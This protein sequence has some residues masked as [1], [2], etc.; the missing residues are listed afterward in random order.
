MVSPP[1]FRGSARR[2]TRF[3]V[4]AT[5]TASAAVTRLGLP[6]LANAQSEEAPVGP[7]AVD[8]PEGDQY[9]D[10]DPSALTDF[11]GALD[12]Y[13]AWVDDPSYGTTWTPDPAQVPPTF[14][15]YATDGRW[16]YSGSDYTWVSDYAWGWV[17]FH[18]GRWV[19]AGGRWLWIP[20]R[21]YA[22]AWVDW[23]VG[24]AST[25][26]L[27][28]SPAPPSWI[29]MGG[30]PFSVGFPSP[31]PWAFVPYGDV[32]AP[33]LPSKAV[34][35]DI[36]LPLVPH[37][38]PYARPGQTASGSGLAPLAQ[39]RPWIH[40]PPPATL[41]IEA[42]RIPHLAPSAAELRARQ[43]ARPS[44]AIPLGA[45]APSP[46]VVRFR[47]PPPAGAAAPR[48]PAAPAPRPAGRGRR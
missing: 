40:G 9:S 3:A 4:I 17:C 18:Y 48:A 21:Q 14:A 35:G 20:G 34:F 23:R 19:L 7:V 15:P 24:D 45:R 43:L 38:R 29:W 1:P 47:P 8:V 13:G 26:V 5:I 42:S 11:R 32:F 6:P 25:A 10:T 41:G 39:A 44:T 27:G 31:E 28:W 16:D 36:A 46:H 33:D 12:P 37:T 30:S 22:G 2:V